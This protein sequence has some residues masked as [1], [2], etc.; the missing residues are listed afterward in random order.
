MEI[1][2]ACPQCGKDSRLSAAED[3]SVLSCPRCGYV[4]LL[5]LDWS[6][7]GRVERCPLC[8]GTEFFRQKDFHQK[9]AATI[10]IAGVVLAMFTKFL[11]IPIAG[12]LVLLLY[13][14]APEILVCYLCRAHVRG[15]VP[16][17]GQ[18]RYDRRV[19]ERVQRARRLGADRQN[20]RKGV[21]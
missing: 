20:S 17:P 19:D 11:S 6:R 9:L 13:A 3:R 12:I 21:R 2:Y 14:I 16:G 15:H 1:G 5:P 10:G 7:E 8:G 18:R 4:G